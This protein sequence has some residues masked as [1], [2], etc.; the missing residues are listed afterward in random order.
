MYIKRTEVKMNGTFTPARNRGAAFN[1][2][3]IVTYPDGSIYRGQLINF[4][5][6]QGETEGEP[7]SL[8]NQ[9]HYDVR[10]G[11]I[12]DPTS[13]TFNMEYL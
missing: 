12:R 10:F 7:N 4:Q 6:I 8:A 13:S 2:D 3:G 5:K 9:R 1:F 11:M